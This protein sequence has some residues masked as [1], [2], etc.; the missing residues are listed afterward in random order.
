MSLFSNRD[1]SFICQFE[2]EKRLAGQ[3]DIW[4]FDRFFLFFLSRL[5]FERL[6]YLHG[7]V[8]GLWLFDLW[9]LDLGSFDWLWGFGCFGLLGYY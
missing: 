7:L 9:C 2:L 6:N 8:L 1:L 3:L 5:E 4:L